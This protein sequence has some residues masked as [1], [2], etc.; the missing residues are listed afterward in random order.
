[1]KITIVGV[2]TKK[3]IDFD[4]IPLAI[5]ISNGKTKYYHR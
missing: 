1:M 3:M 4:D 5:K 2:N